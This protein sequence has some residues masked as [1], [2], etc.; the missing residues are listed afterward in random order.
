MPV[1]YSDLL[2]L[3]VDTE[4]AMVLRLEWRDGSLVFIDPSDET[5]R[6]KLTPTHDPQTFTVAPGVR[7]SGEHAVFVRDAGG[8]VVSVFLAAGTLLRFGPVGA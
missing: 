1:A 7:E 3:Y 2:G 4:Q 5:W 8:Q 6:P